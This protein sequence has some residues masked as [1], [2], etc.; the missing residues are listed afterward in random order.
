MILQLIK[1]ELLMFWRRPRELVVLLLMPFVLIS[2]LGAALGA[3]NNGEPIDFDI[4]LAVVQNDDIAASEENLINQLAG[5]GMSEEEKNTAIAS[6]KAFSPVH[7][8]LD[9]VFESDELKDSIEVVRLDREPSDEEIQDYHGVL[10]IPS[11]FTEQFFQYA[12][13]DAKKA[14]EITL[15]INESSYLEGSILKDIITSYQDEITFWTTTQSLGLNSEE[16]RER[17]LSSV[18]AAS[19]VTEKK[20]INS[21]SY[22][23]IGMCVMFMFYVAGNAATLAFEEKENHIFGRILLANMPIPSF[24][25]GIFVSTIIVTFLQINI[26]FGLS[27]LIHGVRWPN[28]LDYFV[29]S[30]SLCVMVGAFAVLISAISYRINS[31][32]ATQVFSNF[33]IPI[34]AFVGGSF[35]PVAQLGGMFE[36]ISRFSP[37]G[38]GTSAYMKIMQGYSL[39]DVSTQLITVGVT[40][41]LLLVAASFILPKRGEAI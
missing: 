31:G 40:S 9:E 25:S 23:A 28:L 4:K 34:I 1:K 16:L 18:G 30:G 35:V 12:F 17:I 33:L 15:K 13:L 14:P 2:I 37:G 19:T 38:A 3:F 5:L 11:H 41:L 32:G 8:L 39:G 21:V 36:S 7:I 26:L 24:F 20:A 27:A 6:V 29:V 10:T 22:Y